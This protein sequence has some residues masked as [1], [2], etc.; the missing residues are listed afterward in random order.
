MKFITL[1][2]F[3]VAAWLSFSAYCHGKPGDY[4]VNKLPV[5][6]G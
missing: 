5:W 2:V 3:A 4:L 1:V 6:R